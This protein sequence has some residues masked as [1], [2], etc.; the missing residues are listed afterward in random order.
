M[1]EVPNSAPLLE[2]LPSDEYE[3]ARKQNIVESDRLSITHVYAV[4]SIKKWPASLEISYGAR[5]FHL[6][7]SA[8]DMIKPGTKVLVVQH[9]ENPLSPVDGVYVL[10]ENLMERKE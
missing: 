9:S 3:I 2:S 8:S 6:P 4:E 1:E 7:I 10:G 5:S